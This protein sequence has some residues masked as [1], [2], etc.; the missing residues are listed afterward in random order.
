MK[1]EEILLLTSREIQSLLT[2]EECIGAV[3]RAFRAYGEGRAVPPAVLSMHT[4]DGGF[5]IKTG[6]LELHR[7]YF[8]AKVNGTFRR[9]VHD[10]ACLPFRESLFSVTLG[11]GLH[12]Q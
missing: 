1:S 6:V 4:E 10:L 12:W 7:S 11:M 3:E 2:L 5:H 9:T 8:A